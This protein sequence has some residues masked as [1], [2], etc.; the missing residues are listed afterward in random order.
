MKQGM[1]ANEIP[2]FQI[3]KRTSNPWLSQIML[4][5]YPLSA[6]VS[7]LDGKSEDK[8]SENAF[9]AARELSDKIRDCK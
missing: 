3:E 5:V 4:I 7:E 6:A 2:N 9:R 1:K 8:V